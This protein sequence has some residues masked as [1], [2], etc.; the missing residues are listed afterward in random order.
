MLLNDNLLRGKLVRLTA[1]NPETDAELFA[2]WSRDSEY[3]RLLDSEPVLPQTAASFKQD[4]ERRAEKYE[5]N[6]FV[7]TIRTLAEDKPIGFIGLVGISWTHGD[8]WVA[9]GLGEREY[10]GRGYGGDAMRVA[11]HYAFT[12]LNL[13]RVSLGVFD[14][15]RRAIRSYEKAG[16]VHEGR[17][18]EML[19][20]DGQRWDI[21]LM[22]IL[23]SEWRAA[24][25]SEA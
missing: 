18:R 12:E 11:L 16:F 21:L 15:N 5:A 19:H 3:F 20:R 1:S 10:W 4:M 24:S 2:K 6:S 8:S 22:G 23:R 14:Y 13:H 9:I 7:F 25:S 17:Q